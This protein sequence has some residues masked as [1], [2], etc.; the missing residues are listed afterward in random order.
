MYVLTDSALKE[1]APNVCG[2]VRDTYQKWIN[3]CTMVHCIMWAAMNNEFSRK[4]EDAQL[5]KILQVLNESFGTLDIVERY[6]TSCAI[7]NI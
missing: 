1:P 2:A 3:N 6:K 5:E 4:F 7:F